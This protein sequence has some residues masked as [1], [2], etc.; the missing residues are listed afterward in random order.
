MKTAV[1]ASPIIASNNMDASVM[2]MDAQGMDLATF[3]MRDKIYSNKIRA[4]VREYACNAIDEHKKFGIELPV[5]IGLRY[6]GQETV[7]FC[8]DYAKGLDEN[9]VRNIFG[10]YFRSTK[11]TSNDA[12][13]GF[14]VGSKAGHCYNDTFFVV[15]HFEGVRTT[16]ACML[17]GGESGVPVGHIYKVDENPTDETGLEVSLPIKSSDRSEFEKEI[18]LL[19]CHS[20]AK[21]AHNKT[22]GEQEF[23]FETIVQKEVE[24]FNF[25]LLDAGKP[26][27]TTCYI[28]M[29]GVIYASDSPRND[30]QVIDHHVLVVDVPIGMMSIPISREAFEKTKANDNVLDRI[31]EII[32]EI[33]AKDLEQFKDK[34]ALELV[35]DYLSEMSD[36]EYTGKMFKARKNRLYRDIWPMVSSVSHFG[37]NNGAAEQKDGKPIIVL[38]PENRAESQWQAKLRDFCRQNKKSYYSC[39]EGKYFT[40]KAT[41]QVDKYFCVFSIK[42]LPFPKTSKIKNACSVYDSSGYR[43]NPIGKLSPLDFHNFVR[44]K[45][46]LPEASDESEAAQQVEEHL[47]NV[48]DFS[49]LF[50]YIITQKSIRRSNC[51]IN[52]TCNSHHFISGMS[53]LGWLQYKSPEFMQIFSELESKQKRENELLNTASQ[54]YCDRLCFSEKT[55]ELIQKNIRHATRMSNLIKKIKNENSMRS[56]ILLLVLDTYRQKIFSRQEIRKILKNY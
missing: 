56:K 18:S 24:G 12:I 4:V 14:G 22:N 2:G 30:F 1:I 55:K 40:C 5:D 39:P 35:T 46:D 17:G 7:F 44:K 31:N 50:R 34:N 37:S 9:G 32:K 10:M 48:K 8:R 3:F 16:Y 33:A 28:Q 15:S 11:S 36:T 23:P 53:D 26:V 47:K 13:G 52:Y 54:C 42:K 27:T 49:D 25:R 21:I 29:G 19:V 43:T 45:H 38:I 51:N 6:E 20:P 41:D